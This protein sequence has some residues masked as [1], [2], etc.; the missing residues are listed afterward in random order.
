[1]PAR[2]NTSASGPRTIC[3]VGSGWHFYSGISLFTCMRANAFAGRYVTSAI[4][5]RKLLP[6]RLYPGRLRVGAPVSSARYDPAVA[7][8]DGLDYYWLPSLPRAAAFLRRRRP[9][10]LLLQWWT[11]AV[12]HSYLA[13]ALLARLRGSRIVLEFHEI[14]DTGEGVWNPLPR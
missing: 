1:M 4:L 5:M 13:L 8:F 3:V 6:R 10:I 7:V 14:Q 11:G 2:T 9:D 12:L